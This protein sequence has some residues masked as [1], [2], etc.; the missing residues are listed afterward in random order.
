MK[1]RKELEK[2]IKAFKTF[3]NL[4]RKQQLLFIDRLEKKRKEM[5]E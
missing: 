4:N 3:M 2:L 1:K 5:N